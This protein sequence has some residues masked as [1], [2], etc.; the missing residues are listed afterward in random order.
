MRRLNAFIP[1]LLLIGLL[2]G[3]CPSMLAVRTA[4]ADQAD[5]STTQ[6]DMVK[7][8]VPQPV[9]KNVDVDEPMP[10]TDADV[11]VRTSAV[12]DDAIASGTAGTCL[13]Y[14]TSALQMVVAPADGAHGVLP[15]LYVNKDWPWY[16]YAAYIRTVRFDRG[17]KTGDSLNWAFS[18]GSADT[19]AYNQLESVDFTNLDAADLTQ[20]R[21]ILAYDRTLT[22][23]NMNML[24]ADCITVMNSAFFWDEN[25]T[26]LDLTPIGDAKLVDVGGL[27]S[28]CHNLQA[29]TTGW[30]M[31]S[32]VTAWSMFYDCFNLTQ[33]DAQN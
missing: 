24:N 15:N 7:D 33:I 19:D 9:A 27:C 23:V 6:A 11:T 1:I 28:F 17:V 21:G 13:F 20:M 8:D 12:P 16:R 30:T 26:G 10:L 14:I 29:V 31:R 3:L 22:E 25:L 4:H 2:W 5:T 32:V 18:N